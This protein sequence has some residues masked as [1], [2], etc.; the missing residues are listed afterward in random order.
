MKD[1]AHDLWSKNALNS[2]RCNENG[3]NQVQRSYEKACRIYKRLED[4]LSLYPG[5]SLLD[6]GCGCGEIGHAFRNV[7]G[8]Y[9]GIDLCIHHLSA[10]KKS[11]EN[12][13]FIC[14]DMTR[15]PICYEFD[16]I[17]AITSLEFCY[18][19]LSALNQASAALKDDGQLYIEVRSS[20]FILFRMFSPIMKF[21]AKHKIVNP[22][23]AEGFRD[24][25]LREWTDLLERSGFQ[26]IRQQR[27]IF[28]SRHGGWLIRIKAIAIKGV[29]FMFPI[30]YHFMVGL[31]CTKKMA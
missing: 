11:A 26:I 23:E 12:S 25:G 9:C 30:R 18:E 31:L 24:F 20:D 4:I 27:G 28:Q 3:S 19:K 10:M 2:V 13:F 21:L 7:I 29:A 15:L 8:I 1:M 14:G 16:I 22:Y 6:I 5:C 17:T